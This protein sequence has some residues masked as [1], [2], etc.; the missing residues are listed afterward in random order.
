MRWEAS[1]YNTL[2]IGQQISPFYTLKYM[3][4][5]IYNAQKVGISFDSYVSII[6]YSIYNVS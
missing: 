3:S 1:A 4:E 5:Q 6:N 2:R